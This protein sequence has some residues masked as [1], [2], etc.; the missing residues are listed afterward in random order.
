[1]K[2][3]NIIR[4]MALTIVSVAS[5]STVVLPTAGFT[6]Q[7]TDATVV[8]DANCA[9]GVGAVAQLG[10]GGLTYSITN[11]GIVLSGNGALL[12]GTF[13]QV[14][15]AMPAGTSLTYSYDF[16][17][18]ETLIDPSWSLEITVFD[19]TLGGGSVIAST[20][21]ITG[22]YGLPNTEF[23][24]PGTMLTTLAT[25]PND[26]LTVEYLLN[27]TGVPAGSFTTV[28]VPAVDINT[29]TTAST[30]EP[31]SLALIAGGLLWLGR[32]FRRRGRRPF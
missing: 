13:G 16:F 1:M 8:G 2:N 20:G 7:Y 10:A 21:L 24:S 22:A 9:A 17:L 26:T 30:P 32:K 18:Q 19:D 15:T 3:A 31:G 12:E 6:C 14:A 4:G 29:V 25:N 23:T 28:E 5:A 11:G 27:L